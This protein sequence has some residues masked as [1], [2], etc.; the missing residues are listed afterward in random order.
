MEYHLR[1]NKNGWAV[2]W[3]WEFNCW[4]SIMK[5][6]EIR[7]QEFN[8]GINFPHKIDTIN[9]RM[10]YSNYFV[11]VHTETTQVSGSVCWTVTA[12]PEKTTMELLLT[13]GTLKSTGQPSHHTQPH[14]THTFTVGLPSSPATD[15]SIS[16]SSKHSL[17]SCTCAESNHGNPYP[18]HRG[19]GVLLILLNSSR[20]CHEHSWSE[21]GEKCWRSSQPPPL[22]TTLWQSHSVALF[23]VG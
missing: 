11:P 18:T 1:Q 9:N 23:W 6:S 22:T 10:R 14:T 8:C 2:N 17:S 12:L 20:L 19:A 16:I 21:T 5:R 15:S 13:A 7:L 3:F 4:K